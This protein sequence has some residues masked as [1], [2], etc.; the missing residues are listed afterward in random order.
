MAYGA[1][2]IGEITAIPTAPATANAYYRFDKE[3]RTSLP[4]INTPY[5]KK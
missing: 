2:G 1:K 4:L 3:F 5:K